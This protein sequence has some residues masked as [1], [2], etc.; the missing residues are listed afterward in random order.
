MANSIDLYSPRVLAAVVTHTPPANSFLRD[1]FFS[2]KETFSTH[3]VDIDVKLGTQR[4]APYVHPK[5]GGS[6]M[7]TEGYETWTFTPPMVNPYDLTTADQ[8]FIRLPGEGLYST[9]T[10]TDRA[11]EKLAEEYKALEETIT[12]REEQQA[13][14]ILTTGKVNVTGE[15]VSGQIDFRLHKDHIVQLK[16]AQMWGA[17]GSKPCKNLLEWNRMIQKNGFVNANTAIMGCEARDRLFADEEFL[18]KLDNRNYNFGQV[19]VQ[20]MGMNVSYLGYIADPGLHLYEYNGTYLEK[21]TQTGKTVETVKSFIEPN[22]IIMLPENP[23]YK[24]VYG[25]CVYLDDNKQW[26][27]EESDRVLRSYVKHNPDR[28]FLEV[29]SHPLLV[30]T[31]LNSWMCAKVCD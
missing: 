28:R 21:S 3:Q 17:T 2:V 25:V 8:L 23:E 31:K 26:V 18:K 9:K 20:N 4:I 5:N 16:G 13:A 15:G 12:R 10:P 30:P 7:P 14:E 24:R 6:L 1:K 22:Q 19:N 27:S 11:V 29:Q